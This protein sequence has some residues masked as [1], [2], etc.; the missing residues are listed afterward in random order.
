ENWLV[1][2]VLH[3]SYG[4]STSCR[5][6]EVPKQRDTSQMNE[7][8]SQM[9]VEARTPALDLVFPQPMTNDN[10]NVSRALYSDFRTNLWFSSSER[11]SLLPL[12]KEEPSRETVGGP[13]HSLAACNNNSHSSL[14]EIL[15]NRTVGSSQIARTS[16]HTGFYIGQDLDCWREREDTTNRPLCGDR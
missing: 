4:R 13:K 7:C 10:Y 11:P 14:H 16:E 1:W 15:G 12:K 9:I 6:P 8:F 2:L 5:E 3:I